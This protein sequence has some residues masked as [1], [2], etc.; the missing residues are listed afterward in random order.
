MTVRELHG[1]TPKTVTVDAE[2]NVV[3]VA[4]TQ[5]RFTPRE[6]TLLL[7]SRRAESAPRGSHGWLD[8][9]SVV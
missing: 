9:K 5:S 4:V 2:G 6:V 1:W 3:S 8:R 7:A